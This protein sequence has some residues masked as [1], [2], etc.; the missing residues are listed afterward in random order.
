MYDKIDLIVRDSL[1][2]ADLSEAIPSLVDKLCVLFTEELK[3]TAEA[4]F[5]SAF[6]AGYHC[7]MAEVE[8]TD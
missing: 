6:D 8:V 3:L 7:A 4:S 5:D 2:D 1:F